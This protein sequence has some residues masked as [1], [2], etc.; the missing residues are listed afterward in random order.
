MIKKS[1]SYNNILVLA[2]E[3]E[4]VKIL[5]LNSLVVFL[6]MVLLSNKRGKFCSA[7]CQTAADCSNRN[8]ENRRYFLVGRIFTKEAEH[9]CEL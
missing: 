2:I 8:A 4:F 7:F 9:E 5:H 3:M 1:V 6:N